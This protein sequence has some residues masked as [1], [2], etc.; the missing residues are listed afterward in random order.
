MTA[1]Y[2]WA[3]A[4][5]MYEYATRTGKCIQD[6]K[7][8]FTSSTA[9]YLWLKYAQLLYTVLIDKAVVH[10]TPFTI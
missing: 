1:S 9:K 5:H 3:K 10:V 6:E 8:L 2:G 7:A 4:K